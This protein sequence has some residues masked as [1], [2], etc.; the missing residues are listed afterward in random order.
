MKRIV[1]TPEGMAELDIAGSGRH[2]F[3]EL[4]VFGDDGWAVREEMWSSHHD[5]ALGALVSRLTGLTSNEAERMASDFMSTW[6]E[7]GGRQEGARLTRRLS[8]GVVGALLVVGV[9]AVLGTVAV[10]SIFTSSRS[11]ARKGRCR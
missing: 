11:W 3:V 5:E 4:T 9:L 6:D 2:A 1:T 10:R 7:G 8:L